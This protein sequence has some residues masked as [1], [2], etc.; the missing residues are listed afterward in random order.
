MLMEMMIL[1]WWWGDFNGRH[2][3]FGDEETNSY[4]RNLLRTINE[5]GLTALVPNTPTRPVSN[6]FLDFFLTNN[7]RLMESPVTLHIDPYPTET[8]SDHLMVASKLKFTS[9]TSYSKPYLNYD[10]ANMDLENYEK[11]FW[12][13]P[14]YEILNHQDSPQKAWTT[15]QR[16]QQDF[17]QMVLPCK[18]S[19][20]KSKPWF[21]TKIKRLCKQKYRADRQR[22][23]LKNP[24]H[25]REQW[26]FLFKYSKSLVK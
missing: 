17:I 26:H 13:L 23:N 6:W 9:R 8:L 3:V 2:E 21:N 7:P 20:K 14:W 22:R 11:Y 16:L 4:G 15:F 1:L 24:K 25:L 12:Q 10:F 5:V 19:S 18:Q